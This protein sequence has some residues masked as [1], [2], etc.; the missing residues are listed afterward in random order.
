MRDP[1]P[2][3]PAAAT[4][5]RTRP[6]SLAPREH[7]AYGQLGAP[8]VTALAIGR[9]GVVAIALAAAAVAV[10][11]AH[12][13]VIVLLGG[14]G[15][16]VRSE[17]GARARRR[18]LLL[19]VAAAAL[20]GVALALARPP[21]WWSAA[22][23]AGLGAAALGHVVARVEKTLVGEI[24]AAAALAS[25][26]APVAV[27]SGA[28]VAAAW[29]MWAA[30]ALGFAAITCAVRDVIARGKRRV[31]AWGLAVLAIVAGATAWLGWRES[32]WIRT[33]AP[34]VLVAL[35]LVVAPAAPRRLRQTGWLLVAASLATA[36][37]MLARARG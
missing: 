9:P 34:L 13:P 24:V 31:R 11:L 36:T 3:T 28:P 33:A 2:A 29:W 6:R 27:A 16:R 7:G 10:F 23:A 18:L 37:W 21:V 5:E 26:A 15:A 12:E 25:A 4:A 22:V 17:H 35:G 30:W 1:E 32:A 14:R 8:L 20:A 19:A